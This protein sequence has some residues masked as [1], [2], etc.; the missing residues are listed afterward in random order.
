MPKDLKSTVIKFNSKITAPW[1]GAKENFTYILQ[2][3]T[4]LFQ[5]ALSSLPQ[6]KFL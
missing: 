5:I 3:K 4:E 2:E 1:P 6:S